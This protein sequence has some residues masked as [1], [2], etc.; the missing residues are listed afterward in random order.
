MDHDTRAKKWNS[1]PEDLPAKVL[2]PLD[3]N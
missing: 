3:T 1:G 2:S